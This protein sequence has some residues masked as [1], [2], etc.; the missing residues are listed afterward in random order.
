MCAMGK[1][2]FFCVAVFLIFAIGHIGFYLKKNGEMGGDALKQVDVAEN[3]Y[4]IMETLSSLREVIEN[5]MLHVDD[6]NPSPGLRSMRFGDVF[7]KLKEQGK[8]IEE[9]VAAVREFEKAMDDLSE[10][11]RKLREVSTF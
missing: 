6:I 9:E 4:L 10:A 1:L 5:R 3:P 2:A 7:Q 8:S 11:I